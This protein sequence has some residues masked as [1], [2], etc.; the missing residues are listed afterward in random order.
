LFVGPFALPGWP[1]IATT[2]VATSEDRLFPVAFQQRVARERLGLEPV[3]LPGGHLAALS[4]PD[5]V[6]A[7]LLAAAADLRPGG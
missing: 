5:A 4:Q 1:A 7:V 2:V 3:V 6:A